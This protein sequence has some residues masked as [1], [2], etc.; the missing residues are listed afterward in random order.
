LRVGLPRDRPLAFGKPCPTFL[1][2][3][4]RRTGRVAIDTSPVVEACRRLGLP[5]DYPA[6]EGGRR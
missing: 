3:L 1:R 2:Q 4:G 6:R 5:D